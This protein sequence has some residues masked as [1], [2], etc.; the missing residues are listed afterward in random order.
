M[1]SF[2]LAGA[3]LSELVAEGDYFTGSLRKFTQLKGGVSFNLS[4][5]IGF[6]KLI[7]L[8]GGGRYE[9]TAREGAASVNFT[10]SL[11]DGGLTF[12]VSRNLFLMGG[13]KFLQGRGTEVITL[14]D[15][16]G[17]ISGYL[18]YKYNIDQMVY[19][20][21]LKFG[22]FKNSFASIEYNTLNVSN[23]DVSQQNYSLGNL[24][25]NVTFRF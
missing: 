15:Q 9:K 4:K 21:G 2:Q 5:L 7:L 6:R 14:R 19:S 22:L 11:I 17:S 3:L 1:I 8:N 18:P 12:E 10:S 25:I 23:K 16:F 20:G 24:F 13:I